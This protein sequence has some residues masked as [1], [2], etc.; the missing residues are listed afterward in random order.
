[1]LQALRGRRSESHLVLMTRRAEIKPLAH[2]LDMKLKECPCI[3]R[4]RP[5]PLR[6]IGAAISRL[7]PHEAW[8]LPVLESLLGEI[9]YGKYIISVAGGG[10]RAQ[11]EAPTRL[12]VARDAA[13]CRSLRAMTRRA[14]IGRDT[15]AA[16]AGVL[17]PG[18]S[19][20]DH[21][22]YTVRRGS[23]STASKHARRRWGEANGSGGA[24]RK[25][26]K[27]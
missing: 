23:T 1:M 17:H 9:A 15:V 24:A 16:G 11:G 7:L 3:G 14:E 18:P 2:E 27:S 13:A 26:P 6:D 25:R 4:C 12:M 10:R 19:L 20:A 21:S 5:C 8:S 22:Q